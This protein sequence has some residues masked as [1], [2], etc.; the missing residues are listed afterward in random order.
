MPGTPSLRA[1]LAERSVTGTFLK[2]PRFEVVDLLALAG[3]DFVVCDYEHAQ[4]SV[5][6]AC[7]VVRAGA[8]RGMPVMVRVPALDRGEINRLLEAGAAGANL[9]LSDRSGEREYFGEHARY[10]DPAS[11]ESIRHCVM[12]AWMTA[13]TRD[14]AG[15]QALVAE[16]YTWDRHARETLVVYEEVAARHAD[17]DREAGHDVDGG[18]HHDEEERGCRRQRREQEFHE[19]GDEYD[20][21]QAVIDER[22]GRRIRRLDELGEEQEQRDEDDQVADFEAPDAAAEHRQLEQ[23]VAQDFRSAGDEYDRV[24]ENEREDNG[25][26]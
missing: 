7:E 3:F 15:Q 13:R 5:R 9:V 8:G 18:C 11:I 17:A 6:E 23:R 19:A 12:A 1:L 2:I 26:N 25:R 10:C 4:M 16:T 14:R 22:R 20:H 24:V 21:R